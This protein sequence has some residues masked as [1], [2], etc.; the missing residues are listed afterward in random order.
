MKFR[1][2]VLCALASGLT[3][4]LPT[5]GSA[6]DYGI[7]DARALAM[8]GASVAV[9]KAQQAQFYNPALL[10]FYDGR[11]EDTRNG[12]V[13][14]PI[15]VAQ[16]KDNASDNYDKIN[17]ALDIDLQ[18]AADSFNAAPSTQRAELV[19]SLASDLRTSL[20]DID[21]SSIDGDAFVGFSI[22]EPGHRAGGAFYFGV[23]AVGGGKATLEDADFDLLDDY[24]EAMRFVASAGAEGAVHPEL[25]NED[26][27]LINPSERIASTARVASLGFAEWGLSFS[28]EFKLWG[29]HFALGATPKLMRVD[30]FSENLTYSNTSLNYSEDSRTHYAANIDL[31][32]AI[33]L[34]SYVRLALASKDLAPQDYEAG[35]GLVVTTEARTRLGLAF[36]RKW[37]SLALD[38]DLHEN[39]SVGSEAASQDLSLGMELRPIKYLSL[40]GGWR[41][42]QAGNREDQLSMGLGLQVGRIVADLGYSSGGDIKG[43]GLQFGWI[44]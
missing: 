42:D 29:Q 27:S 37:L 17:D 21:D 32:A 16:L 19:A 3:M 14:L 1:A 34:G 4:G 41:S 26:G 20:E 23:R 30:V 9:A 13:Y 7:Y 33:D 22:S 5:I 6:L 44:F 24:V 39:E 36:E 10:A 2:K 38:Y 11:E 28:K 25:F 18:R 15:A 35:S 43:G 8:G 12:R 40:R 31:G